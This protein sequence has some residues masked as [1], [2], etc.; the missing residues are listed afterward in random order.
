M[1]QVNQNFFSDWNVDMA[2]ILGFWFADGWMSQPDKDCRI[3]FTSADLDHLKAIQLLL[4]SEQ[5]IYARK[6][7]CYDLTIGSKQL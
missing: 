2:Y 6:G 1:K 7:C 3:T 4:T 5:K